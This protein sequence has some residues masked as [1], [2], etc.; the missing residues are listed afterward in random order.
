MHI[1]DPVWFLRGTYSIEYA[2]IIGSSG[3]HI[4]VK[5]EHLN[6]GGS[7]KDRPAKWMILDAERKGN[8]LVIIRAGLSGSIAI[9]SKGCTTQRIPYGELSAPEREWFI[10]IK[11]SG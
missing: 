3:C 4:L 1:L 2:F 10:R 11:G 6:P 9:I 5:C 7:V 8:I